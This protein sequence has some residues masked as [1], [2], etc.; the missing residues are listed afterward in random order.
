M[1]P[2]V[3]KSGHRKGLECS[4]LVTAV[5]IGPVF[6]LHAA[7]LN[8]TVQC[9]VESGECR[10]SVMCVSVLCRFCKGNSHG[11]AHGWYIA[12]LDGFPVSHEK[13]AQYSSVDSCQPSAVWRFASSFRLWLLWSLHSRSRWPSPGTRPACM[14]L[15][16][17]GRLQS[18]NLWYCAGWS[19]T[20]M[21]TCWFCIDC[22]LNIWNLADQLSKLLSDDTW[23]FFLVAE[24]AFQK[25]GVLPVVAQ[26]HWTIWR[27]VF[28]KLPLHE[29]H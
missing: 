16:F 28:Y 7:S 13:W 19:R 17:L 5:I 20:V 14:Q 9:S 1:R 25:E 8:C 15:Y 27:L 22:L 10:R 21:F 6:E 3:V 29:Q 4:L 26:G 23:S 18:H 12:N 11:K 24:N 2:A